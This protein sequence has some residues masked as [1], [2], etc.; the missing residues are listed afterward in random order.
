VNAA[1]IWTSGDICRHYGIS[2]STLRYWRGRPGFPDPLKW[3][4]NGGG[5]WDPREVRAWVRDFRATGSTRRLEV[6]RAFARGP[7]AGNQSAVARRLGVD[8]KTVARYLAEADAD[9]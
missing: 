6:I 8:R 1:A 7:A 4:R 3:S 9:E 5:V 2:A